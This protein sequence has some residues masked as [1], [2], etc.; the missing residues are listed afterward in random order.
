MRKDKVA[1]FLQ[2]LAP[3][4]RYGQ[5]FILSPGHKIRALSS[6][7]LLKFKK[8]KYENSAHYWARGRIGVTYHSFL[9]ANSII[10]T[11]DAISEEEKLEEKEKLLE[12][13]KKAFGNS[14]SQFP[15]WKLK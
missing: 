10:D 8:G 9:D 1:L 5:F 4:P 15:P 7:K 2:Y 13:R 6:L 12:A 11:T 3:E 14:F